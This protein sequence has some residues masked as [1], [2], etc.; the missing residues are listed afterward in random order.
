VRDV[1]PFCIAAGDR[2]RLR[3]LN[4]V[5]LKR[6]GFTAERVRAIKRAYRMLFLGE[7]T[8]SETRARCAAELGAYPDVARML[9]FIAGS[10][11][12]ICATGAPEDDDDE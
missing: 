7:G 2:A 8:L 6:R 11:R 5:G 10:A 9:E 1:P 12:G 3:G 4:V